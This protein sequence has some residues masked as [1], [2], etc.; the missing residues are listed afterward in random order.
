M[1]PVGPLECAGNVCHLKEIEV[2]EAGGCGHDFITSNLLVQPMFRR[3]AVCS[4]SASHLEGHLTRPGVKAKKIGKGPKPKPA[5]T[6]FLTLESS[7][8]MRLIG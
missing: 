8:G 7:Y 1:V 3:S 2:P 4:C 6:A 5:L